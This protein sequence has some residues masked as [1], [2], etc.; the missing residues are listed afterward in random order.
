MAKLRKPSTENVKLKEK[1]TK[2]Q[3]EKALLFR[4]CS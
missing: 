3:N 1:E 2:G 4:S